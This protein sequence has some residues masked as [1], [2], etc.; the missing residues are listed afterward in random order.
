MININQKRH[1]CIDPNHDPN[2]SNKVFAAFCLVKEDHEWNGQCHA[3][4][5]KQAANVLNSL[6]VAVISPVDDSS[7]SLVKDITSD[8]GTDE[9]S[10]VSSNEVIYLFNSPCLFSL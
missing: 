3:C 6:T 7:G 4:A 9:S 8:P 2:K 1:C 5:D 10:S